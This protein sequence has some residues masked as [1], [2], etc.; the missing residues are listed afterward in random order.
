MT[1]MT[2]SGSGSFSQKH[3]SADPDPYQNVMDPQHSID[4]FIL[5]VQYIIYCIIRYR[6]PVNKLLLRNEDDN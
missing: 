3:G 1:K 2:G 6:I 5:H 4:E